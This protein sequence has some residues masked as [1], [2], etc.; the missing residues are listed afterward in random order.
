VLNSKGFILI[1]KQRGD[2]WSLPKGHVEPGES[3]IEAARREIFEES[4]VS[5]LTYLGTLGSYKRL[6]KWS[7]RLQSEELKE[8]Y[9]FLFRTDEECLHPKDPDNPEAQ[10]VPKEAVPDLLSY[11]EDRNFFLSVMDKI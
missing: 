6:K 1:V 4:G 11:E 10:W 5:R 7:A 2:T 8:I 9:L 3:H